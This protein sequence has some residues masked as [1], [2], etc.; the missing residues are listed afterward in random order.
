MEQELIDKI[1]QG[2]E[3]AFEELFRT[4][5]P[6]LCLFAN[7]YVHSP[8]LA[9]DVVQ[10]VFIRICDH[11]EEFDIYNSLKAYLYKAVKN[12]A[13]SQL[14]KE[15]PT[16]D[17][18]EAIDS[19]SNCYEI[20]EEFLFGSRSFSARIWEEVKQLPERKC[21]VFTL[22]QKH[23]LSYK[24]IAQVM[25]ITVKTVENQMGRAVIFLRERLQ[26]VYTSE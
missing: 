25:G 9:R 21:T 15:K 16:V 17:V 24:E 3:K 6:K 13:I 7:Q 14:R 26:E 8:D 19:V 18:S 23:G 22:Y 5:Y 12:Q 2:D 11:P 4:W 1:R 20:D 10:E